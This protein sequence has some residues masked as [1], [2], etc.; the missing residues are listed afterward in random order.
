M[1]CR[2][3]INDI[4]WSILRAAS[5]AVMLVFKSLKFMPKESVLQFSD[6][7]ADITYEFDLEGILAPNSQP[8]GMHHD[9]PNP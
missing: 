2:G 5:S 4:F 1:R 3:A 6:K 8:R 9:D 7:N